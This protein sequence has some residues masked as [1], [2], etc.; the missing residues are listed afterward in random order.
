M[1]ALETGAEVG[2]GFTGA[3]LDDTFWH[4][5]TL[6][7]PSGIDFGN[8]EGPPARRGGAVAGHL[9]ALAVSAHNFSMGFGVLGV[10]ACATGASGGGTSSVSVPTAAVAG[11]VCVQSAGQ[12]ATAIQSLARMCS[13]AGGGQQSQG[14]GGGEDETSA[15]RGSKERTGDP[16]KRRVRPRKKTLEEVEANQPRNASGEMV[17]P[18][19]G[20]PLRPGEVDLGHKRG[21][22]WRMRKGM[23]KEAG[24]T[25]QHVL[26]AENDPS[27]YQFENRSSNR[28]HSFEQKR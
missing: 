23:H 24:S 17:D 28:S 11:A 14:S 4:V 26:E 20:E 27:I 9:V 18:N 6:T 10:S 8:P 21:H 7:S 25:R 13:S 19:T 22:E 2:V 12:G 3:V 5:P 1:S 15:E 16:T